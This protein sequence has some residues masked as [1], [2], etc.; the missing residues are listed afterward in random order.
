MLVSLILM[1]A[2]VCQNGLRLLLGN[3]GE[4]RAH[5][6]EASGRELSRHRAADAHQR[7][8]ASPIDRRRNADAAGEEEAEAAEAG[9]ADFHAD[10]GDREVADGQQLPRPIQP[11]ADAELVRRLA[12]HGV[13]GPR[14]MKD[15]RAHRA[16]G[17]VRGKGARTQ[18][19]RSSCAC[20]RQGR[21]R[22]P[23]DASGAAES[24][25]HGAAVVDDHGNRA[26]PFA[27]TEHPLQL[28]RIFLDVD[29]LER[30]VPPL[31]VLPGGLRVRSRVLAE[32][33]DHASIVRGRIRIRPHVAAC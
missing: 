20:H 5:Q 28:R 26:T 25:R 13:E 22:R 8:D 17:V 16:A 6:R 29:V 27:V 30:H 9:E 10:V 12:E 33:V 21:R 18:L 1:I 15:D 4:R 24:D 23:S 19:W 31:M 3:C 32:D 14:E 11:C 7:T 2:R